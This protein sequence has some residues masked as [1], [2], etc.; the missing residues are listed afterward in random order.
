M[1]VKTYHIINVDT[2]EIEVCAGS[3]KAKA[4]KELEQIKKEQPN[5][6]FKMIPH[7]MY[8]Y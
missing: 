8:V 5:T 6:K 7:E 3:N 4:K 1:Y 2:K